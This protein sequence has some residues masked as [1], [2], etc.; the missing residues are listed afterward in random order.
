MDRIY[1]DNAATTRIYDEVASEMFAL[2]KE[3]YGNP[4]SSH[5]EGA[6]A[7]A[8]LSEARGIVA[9]CLNCEEDE[10]FFTSGGTES[11]NWALYA[12]SP[13][14]KSDGKRRIAVSAVEHAAVLRA[15]EKYYENVDIIKCGSDGRV[16]VSAAEEAITP[17]TAAVSVMFAN[18]ETGAL[19][20]VDGIAGFCREKGIPFHTDA[21]QAVGRVP[22]DLQK[23]KVDMLSA[24]AHK[25]HGPKGTGFLYVRGGRIAPLMV[26]GTQQ[27]GKRAGTQDCIAAYGAA[28]ALQKSVK[29]LIGTS[30]RVTVLRELA[31][32]GISRIEGA[33]IV[34]AG[35]ERLPGILNVCFEGVQGESLAALLDIAGVAASSGP[36]CRGK[37]SDPS[38]AL[39][40]MGIAP[41]LARGELRISFSGFNTREETEYAVAAIERA[42]IKTRQIK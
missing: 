7:A 14:V 29:E 41:E 26:G 10:I 22:V 36:A 31:E 28:L 4:S 39:T 17:D 23:L 34:C 21:V 33:H 24:S 15:A 2:S 1:L 42:V 8:L 13:A 11:D 37:R 40:A 3:Y 32:R 16:T 9:E 19:Q 27:N 30:D 18:N 35:T 25:F 38:R 12:L 20:P 5:S 6:R